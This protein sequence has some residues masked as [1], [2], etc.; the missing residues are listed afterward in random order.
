MYLASGCC[1]SDGRGCVSTRG[2]SGLHRARC[3]VIPGRGTL[4]RRIVQQRTDRRW[5]GSPGTGKGET[6]RQE[7]TAQVV[8]P[9]A[10]QTPAGARPN[11]QRGTARLDQ[12]A[13][14][15]LLEGVG[16]HAPREMAITRSHSYRTRLIG[17]Q[18]STFPTMELPSTEPPLYR[19]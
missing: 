15:R 13:A 14:G 6:V 9:V 2:K 19:A 18:H 7:L 4:P 11:R 3:Q 16:D 10:W 12:D 17:R 1:R 5:P 8:T